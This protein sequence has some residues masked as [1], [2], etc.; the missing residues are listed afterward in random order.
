VSARRPGLPGRAAGARSPSRLR[1]GLVAAG[2]VAVLGALGTSCG[3]HVV[4]KG[5][6]LPSHVKT[7]GVALFDNDTTRPELGQRITENV[8]EELVGR[9]KYQVSSETRGVDAV[10]TGRVLS[11]TSRAIQ[12][13]ESDSTAQKVSVTL[14]AS[15]SFEDR[16]KRRV[17]WQADGYTFTSEYEVFGDPDDYFDTELGAV[18]EVAKDFA[19]AVVSAVL[20]GF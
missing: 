10:L 3:Y 17:T 16:V 4:G 9:G 13:A 6:S 5:S 1:L 14:R 12:L 7:I 2:A 18:E 11:W 15:V 19:R 8:I 20:Q